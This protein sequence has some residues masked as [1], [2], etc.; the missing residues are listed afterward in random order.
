MVGKIKTSGNWMI[1]NLACVTGLLL[2]LGFSAYLKIN[3]KPAMQINSLT[4]KISVTEQVALNQVEVISQRGYKTLI[5]LRPDGEATDQPS[6][7]QIASLAKANNLAFSYIPVPHGE[8]PTSAVDALANALKNQ[9]KP[10][11]LY[12]R[13]GKRAA[14]TW[15]LV[16][17]SRPDGLY[18]E[19][20]LAAVKNSGQSADDLQ[21]IIHQRIEQRQK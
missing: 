16:E 21:D 5:D 6:S 19:S 2:M 4:D 14:R 7:D 3:S 12:C 10:V 13:S 17:A 18:A 20:I 8:I 15:S 1:F 11:L 9:P